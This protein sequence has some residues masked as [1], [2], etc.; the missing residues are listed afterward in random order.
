M[1]RKFRALSGCTPVEM[2]KTGT[3]F[4]EL[5]TNPMLPI[6]QNRVI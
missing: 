5:F 3:A 4:S 6:V 1:I 2:M